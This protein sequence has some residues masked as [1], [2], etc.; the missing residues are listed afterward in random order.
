MEGVKKQQE[1][2]RLGGWQGE[3]LDGDR[4][5]VSKEH[6]N[7]RA[8]EHEEGGEEPCWRCGGAQLGDKEESRNP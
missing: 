3:G 7:T 5:S 1:K 2:E 6:T 8:K 4:D